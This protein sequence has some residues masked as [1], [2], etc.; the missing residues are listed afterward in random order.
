MVLLMLSAETK[1]RQTA[2]ARTLTA[3]EVIAICLFIKFTS[4]V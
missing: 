4:K 3:A 2:T 1:Q